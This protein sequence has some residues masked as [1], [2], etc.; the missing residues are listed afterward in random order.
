[1]KTSLKNFT[2]VLLGVAILGGSAGMAVHAKAQ[3]DAKSEIK[4]SKTRY[5]GNSSVT[6]KYEELPGPPD[7]T[8]NCMSENPN[9]C[10]IQSENQ[11]LPSSLDYSQA[12][13]ANGVQAHPNS[14]DAYY[15]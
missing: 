10:V 11:S 15:Q 8:E 7:F 14:S 9:D 4:S 2:K 13:P 6:G 3:K 12:T 5:W 1:M